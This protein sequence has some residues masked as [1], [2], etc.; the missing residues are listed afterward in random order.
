MSPANSA[1]V[2]CATALASSSARRLI[3]S[4]ILFAADDAQLLAMRVIGERLDDVGARM[5]EVAMELRDRLRMLEHDLRHE[6]ARLQI[7]PPLELEDIAFGADHGTGVETLHERGRAAMSV[8]S[9][10]SILS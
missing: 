6:R 4:Q 8:G 5:D 9:W 2:S 7:A 10:R 1:P 3:G